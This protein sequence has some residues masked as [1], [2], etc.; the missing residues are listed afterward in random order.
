MKSV[1][2]YLGFSLVELMIVV[3]V[4]GIL[5][6]VALPTFSNNSQKAKEAAAKENLRILR[7]AVQRYAIK[8][9]DVAPGYP[10]NDKTKIPSWTT[11]IAQMKVNERYLPILPPN[12][13]N[14]NTVTQI[15]RNGQALPTQPSGST[16][17]IYKPQTKTIKLNKTGN[18]SSGTPYYDY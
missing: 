8:H 15:I 18:D 12:P 9:N 14:N 10:N 16:G 13:F 17:W 3:A 2:N 5:A 4:L 7:E 6:A 11:F 1:A